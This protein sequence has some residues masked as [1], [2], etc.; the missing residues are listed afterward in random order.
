[1]NDMIIDDT[2]AGGTSIHALKSHLNNVG[3]TPQ[4]QP[5]NQQAQQYAQMQ[6]QQYAQMQAQQYAQ[7]QAQQAQEAYKQTNKQSI[8]KK[9]KNKNIASLASDIN[10]S[11][12]NYSPINTLK[13]ELYSGDIEH[14][15]IAPSGN[16]FFKTIFI[17][18][19]LYVIVSQSFVRSLFGKYIS[20]MRPSNN[21]NL[22][23][24]GLII[25]GLIMGILFVIFQKIF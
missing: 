16:P 3:Y 25:N 9:R 19:I 10:K 1:M 13:K 23:L 5:N 14:M 24:I 2:H 4:Q 7:M 18:C 11:L 20:Y 12:D 22:T 6:A 8:K 21:G 15:E 17:I